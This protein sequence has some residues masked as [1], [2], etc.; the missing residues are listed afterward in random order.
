MIGYFN[1]RKTIYDLIARME[2][3]DIDIRS[4]FARNQDC[5]GRKVILDG[6]RYDRIPVHGRFAFP[7]KVFVAKI[8]GSHECGNDDHNEQRP[9]K[10]MP[11]I[12]V[13]GDAFVQRSGQVPGSGSLG[14]TVSRRNRIIGA[15]FSK[16]TVFVHEANPMPDLGLFATGLIVSGWW[17]DTDCSIRDIA[18]T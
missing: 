9:D 16:S 11:A 13:G 12:P 14:I 2:F 17:L 10:T 5:M 15:A 7:G 18:A 6:C 1:C 4:V 8:S 3:T